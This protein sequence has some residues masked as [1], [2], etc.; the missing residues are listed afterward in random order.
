MRFCI[1][2]IWN[3]FNH[4][5]PKIINNKHIFSNTMV[6][7]CSIIQKKTTI[8]AK[9]RVKCF[10][11]TSFFFVSVKLSIM[12]GISW[13][14]SYFISSYL[15]KHDLIKKITS[16]WL[17][18]YVFFSFAKMDSTSTIFFSE[19][20]NEKTF[21]FKRQMHFAFLYFWSLISLCSP[22]LSKHLSKK[23]RFRLF[24]VAQ[25]FSVFKNEFFT[26]S[27]FFSGAR[28]HQKIFFCVW[29]RNAFLHFKA[30]YFDNENGVFEPLHLCPVQKPVKMVQWEKSDPPSSPTHNLHYNDTHSPTVFNELRTHVYLTFFRTWSFVYLS[31]MN[32]MEWKTR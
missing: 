5:S 30:S 7:Y 27:F 8:L 23:K 19:K 9:N 31:L 29:K 12:F 4:G 14:A 11:V 6:I 32:T 1:L 28:R 16:V 17:E 2:C 22:N 10:A 20:Q 15:S 26:L 3:K 24:W 18:L 21:L 25:F 13:L